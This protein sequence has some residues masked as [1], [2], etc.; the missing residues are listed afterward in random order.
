M[1]SLGKNADTSTRTFDPKFNLLFFGGL[2]WQ[3]SGL[4]P[5]SVLRNHS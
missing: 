5:E 2:T 4:I 3:C 1:L